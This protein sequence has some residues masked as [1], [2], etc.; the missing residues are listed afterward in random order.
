M[1]ADQTQSQYYSHMADEGH[2]LF[3][4]MRDD[5]LHEPACDQGCWAGPL[6]G[7]S[8]GVRLFGKGGSGGRI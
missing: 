6:Q 7:C 4:E 3:I 2:V 5:R 1:N 8:R